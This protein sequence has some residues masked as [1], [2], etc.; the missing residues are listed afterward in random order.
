M[1]T[2]LDPSFL[3]AVALCTAFKPEQTKRAQAACLYIGLRGL[4]F[5]GADIPEEITGGDMHVAGI[6]TGCLSSIKLLEVV[7]RVKSPKEN[8]KGRKLNVF[9]IPANRVAAAKAWLRANEF[10]P[11]VTLQAE[12]SLEGAA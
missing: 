7:A 10:A 12:F 11:C 1:S 3:Q 2:T 9:R 8:A 5:T 4:D 6:A